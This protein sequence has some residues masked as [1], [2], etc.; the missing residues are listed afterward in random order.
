M[1]E[2]SIATAPIF[3]SKHKGATHFFKKLI[4]PKKHCFIFTLNKKDVVSKN[5][6]TVDGPFASLAKKVNTIN[7]MTAPTKLFVKTIKSTSP[8]HSQNSEYETC[9]NF[10]N[11][12][13][14]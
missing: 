7:L 14:E 8:T 2:V 1:M 6:E 4:D 5:Y 13:H 10:L 12:E 9:S 11:H 3:K